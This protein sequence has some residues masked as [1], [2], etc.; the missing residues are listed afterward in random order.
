[1]KL[2]EGS[3]FWLGY[4]DNVCKLIHPEWVEKG[5]IIKGKDDLLFPREFQKK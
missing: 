3:K 1:M 5:T 4:T 2:D